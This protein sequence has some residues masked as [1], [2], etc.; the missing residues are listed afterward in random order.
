MNKYLFIAL[1]MALGL[2]ARA[3]IS[4]QKIIKIGVKAGVNFSAFTRDVAPFDPHIQGYWDT[5]DNNSNTN[6]YAGVTLDYNIAERWSVGT[7]LL[8]SA[9][10]M[11][12]NEENND[13]IVYD[14][15][16]NEEQAYNLFKFDVDYVELPLTLNFNV[17]PS[18]SSVWL[19]VYGGIAR[20]AAVYKK[21]N[22]TYPKVKGYRPPDDGGKEE[23][24][25]VRT[26]NTTAIGGVKIGGKPVFKKSNFVFYGDVRGAYTLNPVFNRS[27]ADSGGNLDTRMFTL[28]MGIGMQF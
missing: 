28:S 17:L 3:Q 11:M 14:K 12:Y 8:Y 18:R 27:K 4:F 9:K 23:L 1:A 10:G 19:K 22:L 20:G 24:K 13:V 5:F 2:S 16:G 25:Y 7:E 6:G 26:F 15:E 21:T